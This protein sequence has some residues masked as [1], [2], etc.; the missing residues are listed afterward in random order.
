MLARGFSI[1]RRDGKAIVDPGTTRVGERIE[2]TFAKGT[3]WSTINKIE[4][5]D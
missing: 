5:H 4:R 3:T 2:T 1:T